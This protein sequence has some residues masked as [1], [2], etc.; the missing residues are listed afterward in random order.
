MANK[1]LANCSKICFM[2]FYNMSLTLC[3]VHPAA[4]LKIHRNTQHKTCYP[5]NP[6]DGH[7]T[8]L[9]LPPLAF[10]KMETRFFP[11]EAAVTT[12]W[13]D[14]DPHNHDLGSQNSNVF[15]ASLSENTVSIFPTD[16]CKG[17]W[18]ASLGES[19]R[20]VSSRFHT[21]FPSSERF[22]GEPG[23]KS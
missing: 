1:I 5:P 8:V 17:T 10:G 7:L 6:H 4:P 20:K 21:I 2:N 11:S 16:R 15:L 23:S 12:T 3:D 14:V 13:K 9:C 19:P 18:H 22:S